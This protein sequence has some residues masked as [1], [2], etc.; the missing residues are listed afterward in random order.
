MITGVV[1]L[2]R[3]E[4]QSWVIKAESW[5]KYDECSHEL[6]IMTCIF[7][8]IFKLINDSLQ[9]QSSNAYIFWILMQ[10]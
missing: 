7:E 9:G 3:K 10:L 5:K 8:Y 4:L 1:H 2:I 6:E